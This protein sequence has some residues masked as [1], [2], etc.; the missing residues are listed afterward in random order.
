MIL[1][2][3]IRPENIRGVVYVDAETPGRVS[4]VKLILEDGHIHT[5]H[6]DDLPILNS[7]ECLPNAVQPYTFMDNPR[8]KVIVF[9]SQFGLSVVYHKLPIARQNVRGIALDWAF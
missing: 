2:R 3:D 7:A 4:A 1:L 9:G 6:G 5:Y 8:T